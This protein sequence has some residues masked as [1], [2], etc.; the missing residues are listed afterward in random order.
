MVDL[1]LMKRDMQ[2]VRAVGGMEQG[3]SDDHVVLC[4]VRLVGE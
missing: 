3:L 1:V 2:D 4:K